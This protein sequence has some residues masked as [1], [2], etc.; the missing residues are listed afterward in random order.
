MSGKLWNK[1][2]KSG[3]RAAHAI[4]IDDII[5]QKINVVIDGYVIYETFRNATLADINIL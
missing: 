3:V 1:K 4:R 5:T 2:W